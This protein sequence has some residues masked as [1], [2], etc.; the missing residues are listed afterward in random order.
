MLQNEVSELED[1]VSTL[2]YDID[3]KEY[4]LS[5]LSKDIEKIEEKK[6]YEQRR[7]DSLLGL[8][9]EKLRDEERN[10]KNQKDNLEKERDE[11]S[12]KVLDKNDYIAL[13]NFYL[14]RKIII[15]FIIFLFAVI[16]L[17]LYLNSYDRQL[18]IYN[19]SLEDYNTQIANINNKIDKKENSTEMQLYQTNCINRD[20]PEEDFIYSCSYNKENNIDPLNEEI[21]KLEQQKKELVKPQEP[22]V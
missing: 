5:D 7:V 2:N 13:V 14:K 22:K 6:S 16:S 9:K 4:I 10:L 19:K 8:E 18:G 20:E 3:N 15:I 12:K 11:F 1:Q 21:G 17:F